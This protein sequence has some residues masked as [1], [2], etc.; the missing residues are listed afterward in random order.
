[1]LLIIH[2]MVLLSAV[3]N[4]V[5]DI[6]MLKMA[7]QNNLDWPPANNNKKKKIILQLV[8]LSRDSSLLGY[9]P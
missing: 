5:T 7:N 3:L 6:A 4:S 1:M 9:L 2:K 8:E